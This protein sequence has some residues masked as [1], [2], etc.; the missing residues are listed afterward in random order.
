MDVTPLVF[1]VAGDTGRREDLRRVVQGT[2]MTGLASSICHIMPGTCMALSTLVGEETMC[3]DNFPRRQGRFLATDH[4]RHHSPQEQRH[5]N[6]CQAPLG[7][8]TGGE[9]VSGDI[10]DLFLGC[11]RA[12]DLTLFNDNSR[13]GSGRKARPQRIRANLYL[14]TLRELLLPDGS[15]IDKCASSTTTVSQDTG[16]SHALKR[17]MV[18]G[19]A[20]IVQMD[21]IARASTNLEP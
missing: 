12:T 1:S 19:D 9:P 2:I 16:V 21:I 10:D 18:E 5:T 17:R 7:K 15:P 20:Q 3:C 6:S 8:K 4:G 13:R 11:R 14:I